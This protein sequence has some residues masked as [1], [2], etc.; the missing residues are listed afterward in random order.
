MSRLGQGLQAGLASRSAQAKAAEN[1]QYRDAM[2]LLEAQKARA[3]GI[4]DPFKNYNSKI[5]DLSASLVGLGI[6]Q[7]E[8]KAQAEIIFASTGGLVMEG[9][10]NER[11]D[12]LRRII[13]NSTGRFD[14][15]A[16]DVK[17]D[18]IP[19][20]LSLITNTNEAK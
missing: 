18:R 12:L 7:D 4:P 10:V 1:K 3:A 20:A 13:K 14:I 9:D 5:S 16:P 17:L 2:L 15:G 8:A 19:T 11:N 6:P